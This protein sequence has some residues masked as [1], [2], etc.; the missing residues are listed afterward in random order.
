[1]RQHQRLLL[2]LTMLTIA[3]TGVSHGAKPKVDVIVDAESTEA[4]IMK[5]AV[6]HSPSDYAI[7]VTVQRPL[8][9]PAGSTNEI[10]VYKRD[11]A[12]DDWG[13]PQILIQP[14]VVNSYPARITSPNADD[15]FYYTY[16][17]A[18]GDAGA[19]YRHGETGGFLD[20][21]LWSGN[22]NLG[23]GGGRILA[24]GHESFTTPTAQQGVVVLWKPEEVLLFR[25]DGFANLVV[26]PQ[27]VTLP[28]GTNGD[29]VHMGDVDGETLDEI[30]V[31]A[32]ATQRITIMKDSAPFKVFNRRP[33]TMRSE[34]TED[35]AE[36][37][38]T[39][40]LLQSYTIQGYRDF[41]IGDIDGDAFDDIVGVVGTPAQLQYHKSNGSSAPF[42]PSRVTLY[43]VSPTSNVVGLADMTGSTLPEVFTGGDLSPT[44]GLLEAFGNSSG[45][46]VLEGQYQSAVAKQLILAGNREFVA[47]SLVP[48]APVVEVFDLGSTG[49][50]RSTRTLT[51]AAGRDPNTPSTVRF[52]LDDGTPVPTAE[53]TVYQNNLGATLGAGNID[54]NVTLY[55]EDEVLTGP[56]A[57]PNFG[58]QVRGIRKDTDPAKPLD[59]LGI[60]KVN[61]FAYGTLK[62]GV[63]VEGA[64]VDN[65][66][67]FDEIITGAGPGAVFGPHV[68]GWNFD[69]VL[70]QPISKIN[71]FGYGTLKYG[72]N[73][74]R[75]DVDAD[76]YQ[77]ILT[78]PGPG[79]MF[80]PQI[81]AFNVDGGAVTAISKINFVA[82]GGGT[83][84]G[85]A[86]GGN[87]DG[88]PADEIVVGRGFDISQ[89]SDVMG[90]N[91]DGTAVQAIAGY[92]LTPFTSSYGVRV[93]LGDLGGGPGDETAELVV[94]AGPNPN[95]D[96][97]VIVFSFT[98]GSFGETARFEAFPPAGSYPGGKFGANVGSALLGY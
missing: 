4:H 47:S 26:P 64:N 24:A 15:I 78:A 68:R 83:H 42:D 23:G 70:V 36:T 5:L 33:S 66:T 86:V 11:P 53:I 93:A 39:Y 49:S 98:G 7:V 55:G 18:T 52:Y 46:L 76:G 92:T 65:D 29:R 63:N 88:D 38:G 54:G 56:E 74:S 22:S 48:S 71:F 69:N 75:G 28:S 87:V 19:G 17:A 79:I 58:P 94:G 73:V 51:G 34:K 96:T 6:V 44:E 67:A 72:V 10:R 35:L 30:V 8:P 85:K 1:M 77:E 97:T 95:A 21:P 61:F 41:E 43:S 16:N 81:R 59:T 27:V 40:V 90:Y 2:T 45:S 50:L 12:T 91:Y 80:P 31:G 60:P 32:S 3:V 84:G 20:V 9:L 37:R 89:A 62:Y 57:N 13:A 25:H 82:F 14:Y